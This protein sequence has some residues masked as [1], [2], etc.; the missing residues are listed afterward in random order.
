MTKKQVLKAV[1]ARLDA[2]GHGIDFDVVD[3][4]VRAED[5]W[6]YVPVISRRNGRAVTRDA[7]VNIYANVEN[8]LH[9]EEKLTVLFIPIVD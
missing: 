1:R 6:W 2:V 9:E 8:E 7:T 5:D 3:A 4:G